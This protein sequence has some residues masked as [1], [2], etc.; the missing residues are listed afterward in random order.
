MMIRIK[1][2]ANVFNRPVRVMRLAVESNG[3]PV[4]KYRMIGIRIIK[5]TRTI[6]HKT[7]NRK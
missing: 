3:D 6:N 7:A 5:K 2:Y 4:I 1:I